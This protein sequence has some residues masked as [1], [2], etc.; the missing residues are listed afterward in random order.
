MTASTVVPSFLGAGGAAGRKSRLPWFSLTVLG[1]R[2]RGA[3][4]LTDGLGAGREGAGAYVS[5]GIILDDGRSRKSG[6]WTARD[7]LGVAGAAADA[8]AA[9]AMIFGPSALIGGADGCNWGAR[10]PVI[11]GCPLRVSP[12]LRPQRRQRVSPVPFREPQ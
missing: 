10:L 12:G 6:T 8:P 2:G 1:R 9:A 3:L 11:R 4:G 7:R 5:I